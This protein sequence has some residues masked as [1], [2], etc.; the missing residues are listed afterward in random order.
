MHKAMTDNGAFPE[1]TGPF[2]WTLYELAVGVDKAHASF[3]RKQALKMGAGARRSADWAAWILE[4]RAT[5]DYGEAEEVDAASPL[6]TGPRIQIYA[7]SNSRGP[8]NG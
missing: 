6:S 4:K 2:E 7:P 1:G 3:V 8:V 5:R